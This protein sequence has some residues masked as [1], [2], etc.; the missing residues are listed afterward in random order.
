MLSAEYQDWPQ[1]L[2]CIAELI[3]PELALTLARECGGIEKVYIPRKP[4][5]EHLWVIAIGPKAFRVLAKV[6]GGEYVSLPR[7]HYVTLQKRRIIE[8]AQTGLNRRQIALRCHVTERYVRRTLAGLG[9]SQV[10]R[11]P[12]ANPRQRRV[13]RS[14]A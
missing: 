6:Y 8:L 3:G 13:V 2:G 5:P 4:N 1:M 10:R 7:G 11:H 9:L 14:A 12:R